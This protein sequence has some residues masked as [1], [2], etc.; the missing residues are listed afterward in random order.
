[1]PDEPVESLCTL[2]D[3]LDAHVTTE[4]RQRVYSSVAQ[5]FESFYAFHGDFDANA[6]D[7]TRK[8]VCRQLVRSIERWCRQIQDIEPIDPQYI[9][10]R[11]RVCQHFNRW[12]LQVGLL[13]PSTGARRTNIGSLLE[14]Q[15]ILM[16]HFCQYLLAMLRQH[17]HNF[18]VHRH[19]IAF[20]QHRCVVVGWRIWRTIPRKMQSFDLFQEIVTFGHCQLPNFNDTNEV[21]KFLKDFDPNKSQF[22]NGINHVIAYLDGQIKNSILP[23]LR[24]I[25]GDPYFGY[26]DLGVAARCT[27]P[28]I[29]R[30]LRNFGLADREIDEYK[31]L[32][33]C[34]RD[35]KKEVG[36]AV[37][38]LTDSD[39]QE[40]G[41]IYLTR[42]TRAID[43]LNGTDVKTRLKQIGKIVRDF[44]LRRPVYFDAKINES[45]S[46]S[47]VIPSDG[48]S[49][50]EYQITK[51]RWEITNIEVENICTEVSESPKIPS[52]K[53]LFWLY[54]GLGFNQTQIGLILQANFSFAPED[55]FDP[56]PGSVSRRLSRSHRNL[57]DRI[58]TALHNPAPTISKQAIDIEIGGWL[59]RHFDALVASHIFESAATLGINDRIQQL[60]ASDEHQ[61]IESLTNC[62]HQQIDLQIPSELFRSIII[63]LLKQSFYQPVITKLEY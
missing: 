4:T 43:I 32:W 19:W 56:N 12:C 35:Y 24:K 46:F 49:S 40:I 48:S 61:L 39:F 36:R 27:E 34:F 9:T 51:E 5:S 62:F 54:Y 38:L 60:S 58:H 14:P 11:G 10:D 30:S 20:Y 6:T 28:K 3:G 33:T 1:M 47:D 13:H 50:I 59:K 42:S 29:D 26:T 18:T 55:R 25:L 8:L 22:V 21:N 7:G 17:P 44:M 53:Q 63:K 52:H 57:F 16:E 45:Q 41:R 31:I 23:D 2:D 15:T 37:N